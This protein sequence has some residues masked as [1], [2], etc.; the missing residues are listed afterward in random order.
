[1][2][3]AHKWSALELPHLPPTP[4]TTSNTSLRSAPFT[5]SHC[6]PPTSQADFIL[7]PGLHVYIYEVPHSRP[8]KLFPM[9][10]RLAKLSHHL[11]G[12]SVWP[13]LPSS[14]TLASSREA[15]SWRTCMRY[16]R[17]VSASWREVGGLNIY[18]EWSA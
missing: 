7:R 3:F 13:P 4:G 2:S 18:E 11:L 9:N 10:F 1:L 8:H 17:N 6:K 15:S 14:N 16:W 12:R 5:Q